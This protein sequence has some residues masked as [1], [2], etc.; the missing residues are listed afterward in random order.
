[1]RRKITY[2]PGTLLLFVRKN[3]FP[4]RQQLFCLLHILVRLILPDNS[5]GRT[6]LPAAAAKIT[7]SR[8]LEKCG[9]TSRGTGHNP[10]FIS[11]LGIAA[12]VTMGPAVLYN[13]LPGANNRT[14]TAG[15]AGIGYSVR[16]GNP[17]LFTSIVRLYRKHYSIP[18]TPPH[19]RQ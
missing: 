17:P 16:H 14:V 11:I 19:G 6:N 12:A 2:P 5:T 4:A 15:N 10:T 1:L 8:Y 3:H 9:R 18:A 7:V 13:C